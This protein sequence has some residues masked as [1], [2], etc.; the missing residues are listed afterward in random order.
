MPDHQLRPEDAPERSPL[1][2]PDGL[3]LP[4]PEHTALELEEV[5]DLAGPSALDAPEPSSVMERIQGSPTGFVML[6]TEEV[7]D[8]ARLLQDA[9]TDEWEDGPSRG[10]EALRAWR[11]RARIAPQP[12]PKLAGVGKLATLMGLTMAVLLVAALVGAQAW[13]SNVQAT[14]DAP[15]PAPAPVLVDAELPAPAMP[16]LPSD[17][18]QAA[19]AATPEPL[20]IQLVDTTILQTWDRD[21]HRYWQFDVTSREAPS[22][23]W[24]DAAG[25]V[26]LDDT[27]CQGR[28]S[29]EV[30]R[31]Y[32]ARTHARLQWE[33]THGAAAGLWSLEA[34]TSQGCQVVDRFHV[35]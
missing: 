35:E 28:V 3:D 34:C 24:R 7:E 22:L 21:G 4:V 30:G 20:P 25:V 19:S 2:A 27:T 15:A 32:V 23:R 29:A 9:P 6:D 16:S 10:E 12:E 17:A 11:T 14:A 18:V 31:C 13:R 1:Q 26:R 8:R 33:L 5:A